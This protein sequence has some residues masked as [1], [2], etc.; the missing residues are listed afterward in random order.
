MINCLGPIQPST[1]KKEKWF[2]FSSNVKKD[3]KAAQVRLRK[4]CLLNCHQQL[5]NRQVKKSQQFIALSC[6]E[7]SLRLQVNVA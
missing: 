1:E 7:L 3:S 5:I 4:S 2:S 6:L